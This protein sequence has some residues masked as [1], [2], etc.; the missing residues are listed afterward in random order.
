MDDGGDGPPEC[1]NK[2]EGIIGEE[3]SQAV[4]TPPFLSTLSTSA[5][6]LSTTVVPP[7]VSA[8]DDDSP[9]SVSEDLDENGMLPR[10]S[11]VIQAD[12]HRFLEATSANFA[13][14]SQ[15]QLL[16]FCL[17]CRG[18]PFCLLEFEHGNRFHVL[19]AVELRLGFET[20]YRCLICSVDSKGVRKTGKNSFCTIKPQ[21]ICDHLYSDDHDRRRRRYRPSV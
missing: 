2:K 19:D 21:N 5:P 12:V 6:S 17:E 13:N 7:S 1:G 14:M 8:S 9:G 10:V 15:V 18:D 16:D 4:E 11:F 3:N 20:S